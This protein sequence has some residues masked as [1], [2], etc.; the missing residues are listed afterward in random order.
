MPISGHGSEERFVATAE[1]RRRWSQDEKL[2]IVGEITGSTVCAVARR[3]N[4]APS[5]LFRWKR[6]LGGVPAPERSEAGFVRV[7]LPAPITAS[8]GDKQVAQD[9][10]DGKIEIAL[11]Q[12]RRVVVGKG[13]DIAM[14]RQ[15]LAMLEPR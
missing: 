11:P 13:A 6:E 5:L 2:A 14:V 1:A 15:I 3:H 7:A 8:A 10:T 12:G 9:A 4:I